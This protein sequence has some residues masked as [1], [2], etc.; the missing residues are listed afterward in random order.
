MTYDALD[1]DLPGHTCC[2]GGERG[3]FHT[4]PKTCVNLSCSMPGSSL[5]ISLL[6]CIMH[7]FLHLPFSHHGPVSELSSSNLFKLFCTGPFNWGEAHF[8]GEKVKQTRRTIKKKSHEKHPTKQQR[9]AT[10]AQPATATR[11]PPARLPVERTA[12]H[13][14][15]HVGTN[16]GTPERTLI[17]Q[18]THLVTVVSI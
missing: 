4:I 17:S 15:L 6:S 3:L 12:K 16:R 13:Q 9:T 8:A 2:C 7:F 1:N 14:R 5:V 11:N 10:R 18:T